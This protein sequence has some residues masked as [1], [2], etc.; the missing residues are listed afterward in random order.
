MKTIQALHIEIEHNIPVLTKVRAYI[1]WIRE[2]LEGRTDA[3]F[4]DW[5]DGKIDRMIKNWKH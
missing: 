1:K 4:H 2:R 5:Y 3:C